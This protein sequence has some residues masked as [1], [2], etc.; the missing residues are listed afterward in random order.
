MQLRIS[1][2]V[3]WRAGLLLVG[4]TA[5]HETF[6]SFDEMETEV[7]RLHVFGVHAATV[8]L[9]GKRWPRWLLQLEWPTPSLFT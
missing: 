7:P 1:D 5:P 9:A 3:L 4:G 2:D 8:W 6:S